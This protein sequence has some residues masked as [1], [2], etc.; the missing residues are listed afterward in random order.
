LIANGHV[1]VLNPNGVFISKDA[2]I[3]TAGF[4]A[5]SMVME[6][7]DFFSGKYNMVGEGSGGYVINNGTINAGDEGYVVLVGAP[8]ANNGTISADKGKVVMA[9]ADKIS[10]DFYGD[11]LINYALDEKTAAKIIGPDGS[12]LSSAVK[13]SGKISAATVVMTANAAKSVFESVVNNEGVIEA[14]SVYD[15]GCIQLLGGA[16]GNVIN[17][18]ELSAKG[19]GAKIEI[20]SADDITVDGIVVVD[21]D[22]TIS[23]VADRDNNG[24]GNIYAGKSSQSVIKSDSGDIKLAGHDINLDKTEII[25]TSGGDL[26]VISSGGYTDSAS[27]VYHVTGSVDIDP[28]DP[29][30]VNTANGNASFDWIK[31]SDNNYNINKGAHIVGDNVII[32]SDADTGYGAYINYGDIVLGA[33]DP[34]RQIPPVPPANAG[35]VVE[36]NYVELDANNGNI[37]ATSDGLIISYGN[38]ELSA[39]QVIGTLPTPI[40][41]YHFDTTAPPVPNTDRSRL[42]NNVQSGAITVDI[43]GTLF[44][45]AMG[46]VNGISGVLQGNAG[47]LNINPLTPGMII[48]NGYYI[49]HEGPMAR[50]YEQAIAQGNAYIANELG[51]VEDLRNGGEYYVGGVP[52]EGTKLD[53]RARFDVFND[54][55]FVPY[56]DLITDLRFVKPC[57]PMEK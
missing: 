57:P 29:V 11:G 47:Y 30:D 46:M 4:L 32:Q 14:A 28:P 20:Q 6:K 36:G 23:I 5:S 31:E 54:A 37:F 56:P 24:S 35:A 3:N 42:E 52:W 39:N 53:N 22:G 27:S 17:T 48:W 25:T 12:N 13:N 16:E 41:V 55:I 44:I 49:E 18:G 26:K 15:N 50:A 40:T 9:A 8:V 45:N 51:R 43:N 19:N 33:P 38:A 7:D 2:S 34:L 1:W 10:V 21:N